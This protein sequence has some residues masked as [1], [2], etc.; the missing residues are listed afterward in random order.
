MAGVLFS[1]AG[2]GHRL[3]MAEESPSPV[4]LGQPQV[5]QGGSADDRKVVF[6]VTNV[7]PKVIASECYRILVRRPDGKLHWKGIVLTMS[8][9]TD[10][11]IAGPP[12]NPGSAK[13]HTVLT[14][15]Y[16]NP[17]AAA[18]EDQAD[19]IEFS[20]GT[21]WGPDKEKKSEFIHGFRRGAASARR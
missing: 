18:I 13:T 7:S 9:S 10:P 1:C 15:Q 11:S 12:L 17:D 5:V 4:R 20:D 3:M 16:E 2:T 8:N 14:P 19:Y 6:T 21:F